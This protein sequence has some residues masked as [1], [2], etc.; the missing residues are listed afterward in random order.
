MEFPSLT[1]FGRLSSV[2]KDF[3]IR[4]C[5]WSFREGQRLLLGEMGPP[6]DLGD[7]SEDSLSLLSPW[8]GE[9]AFLAKIRTACKGFEL[10]HVPGLGFTQ[11]VRH[12]LC[13]GIGNLNFQC[14]RY[15][16]V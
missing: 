10:C 8:C 14:G 5:D 9:P 12:Q 2:L 6:L 3:Q 1:V 13:Y 11:S 16:V 7:P 15:S 4:L